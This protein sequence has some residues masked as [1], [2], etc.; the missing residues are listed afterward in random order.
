VKHCTTLPIVGE[1]GLGSDMTGSPAV[2]VVL[3]DD[4][5]PV[6]LNKRNT[7]VTTVMKNN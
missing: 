2:T 5:I 4:Y 3:I 1:A 7:H 6:N